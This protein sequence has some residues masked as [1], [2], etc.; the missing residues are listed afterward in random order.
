MD[1]KYYHQFLPFKL[2]LVGGVLS[3]IIA[4]APSISNT[5]KADGYQNK[6]VDLYVAQLPTKLEH[7]SFSSIYG[8]SAVSRSASAVAAYVPT[9]IPVV[10]NA[11]GL[12]SRYLAGSDTNN[13]LQQIP[14]LGHLL[15]L[16][17][18]RAQAVCSYGSNCQA[19]VY[20]EAQLFEK[21][22]MARVWSAEMSVPEPTAQVRISDETV[23][24]LAQEILSAFRTDALIR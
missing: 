15:V 23:D 18:V 9:R 8:Q 11:A 14:M 16:R 22:S 24:K 4:C 21:R 2:L 1:L 7:Q 3:L 10:F 13:L 6:I 5:R 20:L 17:T 12:P 19:T